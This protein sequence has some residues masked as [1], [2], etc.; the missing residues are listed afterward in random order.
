MT[1]GDA[2]VDAVVANGADTVFGLPGVQIYPLFDALARRALRVIVPRHEQ[3]A[4]YMA[5]GYAK[6]TGRAG[7]CA[8]VPGPGVLN[9][10]AALVT[11]AGNCSP[12]VCLT[13]QV[14][15]EYL[16][17]GR[18]HLHELEDQRATLRGLAKNALRIEAPADAPA[19]VNA[20]FAEALSGRPGPV[21][22]EM[23]WDKMAAS[24]DVLPLPRALLPASPEPEDEAIE[25]AARLLA[26]A[27]RPMLMCGA[28]AQHA[29]EAVLALAELLDAP[30]TAFRSGRGVVAE[31][32]PLGVAAVAAR[33][34]WDD[35]DVLVG[36][37]SRLEMPYMRW[38][39][40][41]RYEARPPGPKLVRIDIDPLELERLVP[42]VGIV[43]DAAVA[44]RALA[45]R[46]AA[47]LRPTRGASGELP[48]GVQSRGSAE[49][50]AEIARA[51]SL[52]A[53][54]V[55]RI[56]PQ[57]QY[58]EIIR[59]VVPRRGF[60]VPEVSQVGFATYTGAYPVLAPRTYVTE[61]Y[62]G[63]LGFGFPTALGVKAAHPTEAVVSINGDGGFLYGAAE[64]ATAA[65]YSLGVVALVFNNG[66][67]GNVVR[68]Q[69]QLFGGRVIG[70][71]LENPD[72]VR[73][74]ESFGVA[75]VRVSSPEALK[76]E[77][78]R[79]LA[80]DRPA[81]IEITIARG[82]ET[83]PWPLIHMSSRPSA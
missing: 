72:F 52:A 56:R 28:G 8:V 4:G 37:G 73:L 26:A 31:D 47:R 17:R 11:A 45:D 22:V 39:N 55:A 41:M 71:E 80:A 70:G 51:K 81:L 19:I 16:G 59:D 2:I 49:R 74:A 5:M 60:L 34:L 46:L 78:E 10:A 3:A 27:R 57:A 9:A 30:V 82:S 65:Q 83:S 42:D 61:G 14:P 15:S 68:D 20:A 29:G 38:R 40:P 6:S 67:Y 21:A 32:H 64:L 54:L 23:C 7:V 24:E 69:Q 48:G 25:S 66:S 63:T 79:A 53:E 33:E 43:A 12:V 18:G 36:I 50:R 75:A 1:G 77:L 35:V 58:L 76:P 62:Q 44:C 13:G